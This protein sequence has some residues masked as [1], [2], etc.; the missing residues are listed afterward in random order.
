[1]ALH[2]IE[3]EDLQI[4]NDALSD[5]IAFIYRAIL[6][7]PRLSEPSSFLFIF[8]PKASF[9][10]DDSQSQND[11]MSTRCEEGLRDLDSNQD[12]ILQRDVSYH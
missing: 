2:F 6:F 4:L 11:L 7:K 10:S 1:M 5:F 3:S 12:T 8:R 9:E